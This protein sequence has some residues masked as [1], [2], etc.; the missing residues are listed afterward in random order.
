MKNDPKFNIL[1]KMV[2][3]QTEY[4][5]K[6]VCVFLLKSIKAPAIKQKEIQNKSIKNFNIST[7]LWGQIVYENKNSY[8]MET[9][10]NE[11]AQFCQDNKTVWENILNS[12]STDITQPPFYILTKI[13]GIQKGKKY[14]VTINGLLALTEPDFWLTLYKKEPEKYALNKTEKYVLAEDLMETNQQYHIYSNN[15]EFKSYLLSNLVENLP[16]IKK[17][18]KD[19]EA[20]TNKLLTSENLKNILRSSETHEISPLFSL[21]SLGA[22]IKKANIAENLAKHSTMLSDFMPIAPAQDWINAHANK[23]EFSLTAFMS[24]VLNRACGVSY[25][26]LAEKINNKGAVII[27]REPV[28]KSKSAANEAFLRLDYI[29]DGLKD[30]KISEANTLVWYA[31]IMESGNRDL[32]KKSL[33]I[34]DFPEKTEKNE[35]FFKNWYDK[36]V[37]VNA[38][39]KTT[40]TFYWGDV[41]KEYHK[42]KLEA[43]LST[44]P[45]KRRSPKI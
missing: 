14:E 17:A 40:E 32:F 21:E 29:S 2:Y 38:G 23:K 31:S 15:T 18:F 26:K 37:S 16:Q 11:Y 27:K 42:E 44:K 8:R 36:S 25:T 43:Q 41:E 4:F 7:T 33:S 22:I 9:V 45:E 19:D 39:S 28:K 20:F 3:N 12:I 5:D 30:V 24:T 13:D 34:V 35:Y 1:E 6:D 10:A